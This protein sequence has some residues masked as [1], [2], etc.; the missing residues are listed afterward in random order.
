MNFNVFMCCK[1]HQKRGSHVVIVGISA[2][3]CALDSVYLEK[4]GELLTTSEVSK[5]ALLVTQFVNKMRVP[6]DVVPVP[7]C[8]SDGRYASVQVGSAINVHS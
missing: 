2:S 3:Q 1:M 7:Q 5:A 4:Y 8:E 6:G